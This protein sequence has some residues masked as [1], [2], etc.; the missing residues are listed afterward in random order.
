MPGNRTRL[1]SQTF[2]NIT[3]SILYDHAVADSTQ[4]LF[5]GAA[6]LDTQ[7]VHPNIR[8]KTENLHLIKHLYL[9]YHSMEVALPLKQLLLLPEKG[10]MT[11][12]E[13]W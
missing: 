11:A 4:R 7:R 8:T 2:N 9:E 1:T 6:G 5:E 10:L 13:G 3:A 12:E